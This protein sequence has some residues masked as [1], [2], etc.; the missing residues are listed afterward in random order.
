MGT[1]DAR[2]RDLLADPARR[3]VLFLGPQVTFVAG[4][5]LPAPWRTP[6]VALSLVVLGSACTTNAL[7]CGRLHCFLTGPFYLG[8][9]AISLAY[10]LGWLPA[11]GW[12]W[13]AI[14]LAVL[15]GGNLLA[16]L[17]ERA[18]GRYR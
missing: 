1:A 17:P 2:G 4:F 18:W 10:G 14:G 15:V 16:Y 13:L 7:R 3:R 12:G 6:V 9:A 8:M 5:F 11:V